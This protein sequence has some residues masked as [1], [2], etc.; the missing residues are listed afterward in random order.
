MLSAAHLFAPPTARRAPTVPQCTYGDDEETL[1][2]SFCVWRLSPF[3]PCSANFL[4]KL[5]LR[6]HFCRPRRACSIRGRLPAAADLLRDG[7]VVIFLGRDSVRLTASAPR[8]LI[9]D[10][11]RV[12]KVADTFALGIRARLKAHHL[13]AHV[14]NVPLHSQF[15]AALAR[16]ESA[17]PPAPWLITAHRAS[18]VCVV[19]VFELDWASVFTA[20]VVRAIV[21]RLTGGNILHASLALPPQ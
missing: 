21:G 11:V 3:L 9:H 19:G 16:L 18:G 8:Q 13:L 15:M 12:I 5:H 14:H 10:I 7:I 6:K 4:G 17:P 2:G 20:A 1:L